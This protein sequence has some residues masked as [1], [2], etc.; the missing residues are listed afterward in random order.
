MWTYTPVAG[1]F[2]LD[3]SLLDGSDVLGG[4][5]DL[6]S[7]QVLDLE[8]T[9]IELSDGGQPTSGVFG[10]YNPGSMT[11]SAQL[12]TWDSAL[13][14]ELYNGK[15]V[16]LT[17]KNEATYSDPIFGKNTVYFIGFIESLNIDLDPINQI[18]NLTLTA[19]DVAAAAMNFPILITRSDGKASAMQNAIADA[20]NAGKISPYLNSTFFGGSLGTTWETIAGV[21]T[22]NLTIGEGISEYIS[23]EVATVATAYYQDNTGTIYLYYL[24]ETISTNS[25]TGRLIPDSITSNVVIQQDGANVPNAFNLANSVAT[26]SYGTY[27]DGLLSNPTSYSASLDVPTAS[28]EIIADRIAL[29]VP[30]I[31][32]TE[33]TIKSAET[34]QTITFDNTLYGSDY[35]YPSRH[36]WSGEEVRTTPAF[37]GGTYYHT[38]VGT[39]HTITPDYWQTTYQLWKGL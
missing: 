38:I 8:I 36:Y 7:I 16:Y 5:S 21:T 30:A 33:V 31:Q 6:G 22:E 27:A 35:F 3:F 14:Q 12:K 29:Y 13:V 15:E 17:L 19:T 20:R 11:L 28:L 10:V 32:P 4:A 2:R 37:T 26:Y 23:A 18:T 39:S 24:G 9:S 25:E 1:K 34:Y